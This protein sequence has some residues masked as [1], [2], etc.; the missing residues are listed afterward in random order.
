METISGVIE[1]KEVEEG[2]TN[3][4]PWTRYVFHING[5]KYSTF[6]ADIGKEF[7]TGNSVVVEGQ[8]KGNFWT[9]ETMKLG[10]KVIVEAVGKAELKENNKFHLSIEEVRCRALEMALSINP[11]SQIDVIIV[12]AELFEKWILR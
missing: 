1:K 10:E 9:M 12:T 2:K 3:N 7:N 8:M 4:K 6:N 5:K 11:T